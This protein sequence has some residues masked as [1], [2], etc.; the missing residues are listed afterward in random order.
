MTTQDFPADSHIF[1]APNEMIMMRNWARNEHGVEEAYDVEQK[2][3]RLQKLTNPL[4]KWNVC[5]HPMMFLQGS[6][7]WNSLWR[8]DH[9]SILV[10]SCYGVLDDLL[11]TVT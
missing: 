6:H 11:S 2:L 1:Y 10:V 9:K 4:M 5:V 8:K 7:L 3:R